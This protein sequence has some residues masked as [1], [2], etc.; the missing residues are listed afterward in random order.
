MKPVGSGQDGEGGGVEEFWAKLWRK[1][2]ERRPTRFAKDE[3]ISK[4]I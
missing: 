3:Y 1:R 4:G 2:V